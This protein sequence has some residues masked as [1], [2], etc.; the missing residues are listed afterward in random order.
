MAVWE[1]AETEMQTKI[2]ASITPRSPFDTSVRTD[3]Y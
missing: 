1:D 2:E 3:A